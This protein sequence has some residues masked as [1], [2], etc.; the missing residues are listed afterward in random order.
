MRAWQKIFLAL[1][2]VL[3]LLAQLKA[4]AH[5]WWEEVPAFFAIFGFLGC[6]L[7]I[8]GAKYLGKF[9]VSKDPD[10][11]KEEDDV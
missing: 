3:T 11:Y 2:L 4:H 10:Y 9:L 5:Y 6:L 1:V 7:I 8:F